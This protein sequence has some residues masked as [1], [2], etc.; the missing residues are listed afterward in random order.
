LIP[1][2][3]NLSDLSGLIPHDE[4]MEL[5]RLA[6]TIPSQNAIVEIG[7]YKGKSTCYLAAGRYMSGMAG[8]LV[9]AV[10][11]WDLPGNPY[12]KH[13]FSAPE[14]RTI[15]KRQVE[16]LGF[17]EIVRPIRGFSVDVAAEW[18]NGPIGMLFIDGDHSEAAVRADLNAWLPY[19]VNGGIVAFDD[20]DT[21]RNPG[22][23][24]VVDWW[25]NK[26]GIP[27]EVRAERLAV[28]FLP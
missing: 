19:V 26:T 7:S 25:S 8:G 17:D 27:Y 21:P 11:P 6:Q 2:F 20:F 5:L 24:K 4:G 18:L 15:F 3:K 14:V 1:L 9:Y 22:V 16:S 28:F 12:G 13:G 10:D 23:R